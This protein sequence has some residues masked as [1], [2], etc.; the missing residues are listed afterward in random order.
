MYLV[1]AVLYITSTAHATWESYFHEEKE[2]KIIKKNEIPQA[3]GRRRYNSSYT[4]K[5]LLYIRVRSIPSAF[6]L[7]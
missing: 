2:N 5:T 7:L 6:S 1:W 3:D 4:C